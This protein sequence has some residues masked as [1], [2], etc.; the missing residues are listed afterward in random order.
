MPS[1]SHSS[2]SSRSSDPYNQSNLGRGDPST[3]QERPLEDMRK[4]V[5]NVLHILFVHRWA[6]FVP[7]C[8]AATIVFALSLSYPRTYQASTTFERG[9]DMLMLNLPLGPGTGSFTHYRTTMRKDIL[10]DEVLT[11]AVEKLGWVDPAAPGLRDAQGAWTPEGVKAKLAVVGAYRPHLRVSTSSPS[12]HIDYVTL[13]YTGP[14]VEAGKKI[15]DAAKAAYIAQTMVKIRESLDSRHDYFQQ[16]VAGLQEELNGAQQRRNELLFTHPRL[17]P[18][19]P[20]W[21]NQRIISAESQ[22]KELQARK[23]EY[24][25][26]LSIERQYM[27]TQLARKTDARTGGTVGATGALVDPSVAEGAR[28][29][30]Q[31]LDVTRKIT[32]LKAGRGM[33]NAHP[34]IID[35][36]A[37]QQWLEQRIELV[38]DHP[39]GA[40]ATEAPRVEFIL[41]APTEPRDDGALVSAL[42]PASGIRLSALKRRIRDMDLAIQTATTDLAGL[43]DAQRTL[44]PFQESYNRIDTEIAELQ[45]LLLSNQEKKRAFEP[46]LAAIRDGKHIYFKRLKPAFGGSTPVSPKAQATFVLALLAGLGAGAIFVVLAEVFDHIYRNAGQISRSLGLPVLETID[47]IFT[48]A[49]RRRLLI[50]RMVLTPMA[51][52]LALCATGTSASLAYLSIE[53]PQTFQRIMQL[54]ERAA[55]FFADASE[56]KPPG[57]AVKLA[58]AVAPLDA[59]ALADPP[60]PSLN[61]L[62]GA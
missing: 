21:I 48:S 33:T 5:N 61:A 24:E 12:E 19:N 6:F 56:E 52:A 26:D 28:L 25:E 14:D 20:A 11:E 17:D 60:P 49:D 40:V 58:E 53:R 32:G 54:P 35:L 36:V 10:S 4:N 62:D 43:Q 23:A 13:T 29:R 50:K 8:A 46:A 44:T 3:D 18:K 45:G 55:D 57:Q 16:Q 41:Q 51:V 22:R 2:S 38:L 59:A 15:L 9:E 39:P 42:G 30:G 31:L 47:E 27:E 1:R 7:C 34:E 37:R